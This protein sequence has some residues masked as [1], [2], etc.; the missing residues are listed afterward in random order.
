LVEALKIEKESKAMP[1]FL[2]VLTIAAI[3]SVTIAAECA[4][5]IGSSQ[6]DNM[7]NA[8]WGCIPG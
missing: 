1:A 5:V 4:A 7:K 8:A 3:N 6:I 2:L